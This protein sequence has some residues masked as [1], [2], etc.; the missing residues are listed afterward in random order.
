MGPWPSEILADA[1]PATQSHPGWGSAGQAQGHGGEHG[2]VGLYLGGYDHAARPEVMR[3]LGIKAVVNA[4]GPRCTNL[5]RNSFAYFT[6]TPTPGGDTGKD[7]L[8]LGETC[9]LIDA[10]LRAAAERIHGPPPAGGTPNVLVHC[11]SGVSRGPAAVIA[12]L[13]LR[14]G[15]GHE[16]ATGHVIARHPATKVS[17]QLTQEL[18]QFEAHLRSGAMPWA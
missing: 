17:R 8:D 12:F 15:M 13:M 16:E 10:A 1:R 3:A 2:P 6:C 18:A 5:Y 9:R 7:T 11:M 4:V 14:H